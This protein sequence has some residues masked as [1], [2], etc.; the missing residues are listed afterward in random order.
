MDVRIKIGQGNYFPKG[1]IYGG[2]LLLIIGLFTSLNLFIGGLPFMLIGF[3]LSFS[4]CGIE[5]EGAVGMYRLYVYY[6]GIK[7]NG[8]FKNLDV[9]PYLSILKTR[10]SESTYSRTN[11]ATEITES[12]Y[13]LYFLNKNQH[14]K[15]FIERFNNL[16]ACRKRADQLAQLLNK[17]ITAYRPKGSIVIN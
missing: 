8:E 5:I 3:Y 9:Y 17:S 16:Q 7:T 15:V 4:Y 12:Y 13:D 14:K 11:V 6:F 2:Y 1:A 10:E